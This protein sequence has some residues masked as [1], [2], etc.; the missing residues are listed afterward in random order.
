MGSPSL[1]FSEDI[2]DNEP[3]VNVVKMQFWTKQIYTRIRPA[4]RQT[5]WSKWSWILEAVG[6]KRAWNY[7]TPVQSM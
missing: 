6:F 2:E 1:W 4:T 3:E 7:L 5:V